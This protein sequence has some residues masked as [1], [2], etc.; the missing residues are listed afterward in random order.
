[1]RTYCATAVAFL[2]LLGAVLVTFLLISSYNEV[3][4]YPLRVGPLAF[5]LRAYRGAITITA[6]SAADWLP[7]FGRLSWSYHLLGFGLERHIASAAYYTLFLP[8]W[9]LILA[10]LA[11]PYIFLRRT[12]IWLSAR[13]QR[14]AQGLCPACGY[15][16]RAHKAGDRCP[17]CGTIITVPPA[18]AGA[19]G[20][21]GVKG[22]GL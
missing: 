15:D 18:S 10:L 6:F 20:A 22:S 9:L 1:M 7:T 5:L 3:C 16:L 21:G 2:S 4:F 11:Y 14:L 19:D 17:E 12:P 8:Q 13:R